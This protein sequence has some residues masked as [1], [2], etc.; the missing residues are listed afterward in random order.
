MD[1]PKHSSP[2]TS[3]LKRPISIDLR[4]ARTVLV[5]AWII[6][7]AAFGLRI[8]GMGDYPARHATD[9]EF[10]FLWGGL[11]FWDSGVPESWS[12]LGPE[13][14]IGNATYDG[15]GYNIV[16][17]YLD[18]PP[19]F[20]VL[21]GAFARLTSP[22]RIET[23]DKGNTITIWDVDLHRTRWM[24]IPIF[25]VNFWL[26]FSLAGMAFSPRAALVT[27]LFYGFMSHAVAHGRLIVADNLSGMLLLANVWAIQSWLSGR[28][29]HGRM[30]LLTVILTAAATLTKIPAW[31]QV[32]ALIAML[33]V[34]RRPKEIR[35]VLYGF[36]IGFVIY[37]AWIGWYGFPEFLSLMK[38]QSN[39]F[40]GFNA[41]QRM[42]GVPNL[43]DV[44]DL[45]GVVMAGWFCMIAQ[46][47][48][49]GARPVTVIGPAYILAFT[50]FAGDV[51]FGWYAIPF[52]PWF[53]IGLGVTTAQVF[54][55]PRSTLMIAWLLLFLP[56]AFQ[57]IYIAH[58]ELET[59]LRY[60]FVATVAGLL[61]A[62]LLSPNKSRSV[63]RVAVVAIVA[64]VLMRE[65][66]EV[67]NQRTDRLTDT[68][69]YFPEIP[70]EKEE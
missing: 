63:L 8:V 48:R 11:N 61:F 16:R 34:A 52:Y 3:P 39:R 6:F 60:V 64:V 67:T 18:H 10:G 69:K 50:F 62:Y 58:Y 41:F 21:V 15:R 33:V 46:A 29:S 38:S 28:S 9:D 54:S 27:V 44:H 59:V 70:Q 66:Y 56:H 12:D 26:L 24:M 55:R 5:L 40:R 49:R 25:V 23:H 7:I 30:A 19:L 37:L 53:A 4:N 13:L 1:S 51:L 36:A 2:L 45:N 20:T 35:Y 32:P 14:R 31:C 68:V 22:Q 42:S 47:L 65:V 57:T 17:P 43:L